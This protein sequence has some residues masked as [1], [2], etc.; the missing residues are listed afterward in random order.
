MSQQV[1]SICMQIFDANFDQDSQV[2]N[3]FPRPI[4]TRAV[5]ILPTDCRKKCAL[6]VELIG[7]APT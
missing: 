2:T 5:R 6:R 4:V 1:D 3:I 7:C